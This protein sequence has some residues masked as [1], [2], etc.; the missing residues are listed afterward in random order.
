M[1]SWIIHLDT[2]SVKGLSKIFKRGLRNSNGV[3][4]MEGEK[5][6]YSIE[7]ANLWC[8]FANQNALRSYMYIKFC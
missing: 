1:L 7:K 2:P 4:H 6:K 8:S 3:T 5:I